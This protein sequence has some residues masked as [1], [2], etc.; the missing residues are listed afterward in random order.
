MRTLLY[1][2]A[3]LFALMMVAAS[4]SSGS[5][6]RKDGG[7]GNTPPQGYEKGK[8]AFRIESILSDPGSFAGTEITIQGE[9]RGWRGKCPE[10]V[11]RTRS[12]WILEDGTGCIYVTG[13]MPRGLDPAKPANEPVLVRGFVEIFENGK[14][15][16]RAVEVRMG[17]PGPQEP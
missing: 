16:I 1:S 13:L 6:T 15:L 12:D 17:V 14:S 9:Y 4:C 3:L 8:E 7:K 10:S 5:G 2:S 11:P